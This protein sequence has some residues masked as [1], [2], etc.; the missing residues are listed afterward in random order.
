MGGGGP[1]ILRLENSEEGNM[2]EAKCLTCTKGFMSLT[3]T[4][5]QQSEEM[6]CGEGEDAADSVLGWGA[7]SLAGET[8]SVMQQGSQCQ[9][10]GSGLVMSGAN[11]WSKL[12]VQGC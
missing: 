11:V 1:R 3:A 8:T 4:S 5:A 9:C 12:N 10:Q 2:A 6:A 7:F